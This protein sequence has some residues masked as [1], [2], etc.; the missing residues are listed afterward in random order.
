MTFFIRFI[1]S[2]I[3][4]LGFVYLLMAFACAEWNPFIW[5]EFSRRQFVGLAIIAVAGVVCI[6]GINHSFDEFWKYNK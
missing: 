4:V 3:L 5:E 1:L 6:N 2:P